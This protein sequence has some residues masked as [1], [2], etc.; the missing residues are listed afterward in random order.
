[1]GL[2]S[3]QLFNWSQLQE[4]QKS[5]ACITLSISQSKKSAFQMF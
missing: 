1:M 4:I 5:T 3:L 2:E